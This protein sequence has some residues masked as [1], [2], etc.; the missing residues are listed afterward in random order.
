MTNPVFDGEQ[1]E[2]L[3]KQCLTKKVNFDGHTDQKQVVIIG[4]HLSLLLLS[5]YLINS[6]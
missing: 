3:I 4:F 2:K 6:N 1:K 5:S